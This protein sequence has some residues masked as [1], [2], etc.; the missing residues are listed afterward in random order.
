M[1][2]HHKPNQAV[3]GDPEYGHGRGMP[4]RPDQEEL[5]Q[6]TARERAE[7]GLPTGA[8]PDPDAEYRAVREQ[9]ERAVGA[10]EMPSGEATRRT[11]APFPPTRYRG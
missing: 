11:R 2:H 6:R 9:V 3:E 4:R 10:G 7:A 5:D 1:A 8:A